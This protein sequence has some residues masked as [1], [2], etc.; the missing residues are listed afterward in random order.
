MTKT[1]RKPWNPQTDPLGLA[2]VGMMLGADMLAQ[3]RYS[4]KRLRDLDEQQ[5]RDLY[6]DYAA[7]RER[8]LEQ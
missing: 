2:S 8:Y 3:E 7:M 1:R 4:G 6:I 5:Q